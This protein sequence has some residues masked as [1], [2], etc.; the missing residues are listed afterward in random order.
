VEQSSEELN[1]NGGAVNE[2]GRLIVA[3]IPA[4]QAICSADFFA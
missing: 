1:G 4:A 3:W 2:Y